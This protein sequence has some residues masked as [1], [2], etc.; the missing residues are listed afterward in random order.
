MARGRFLRGAVGVGVSM[1]FSASGCR[2]LWL[3]DWEYEAA[4]ASSAL[5]SKRNTEN[6]TKSWQYEEVRRREDE[7]SGSDAGK[8]GTEMGGGDPQEDVGPRGR[9]GWVNSGRRSGHALLSLMQEMEL[10]TG[11]AFF[12]DLSVSLFFSCSI[13]RIGAAT[14]YAVSGLQTRSHLARHL[15]RRQYRP[16][17]LVEHLS[18]AKAQNRTKSGAMSGQLMNGSIALSRKG[19]FGHCA[20]VPV[21]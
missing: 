9:R 13:G 17:A 15:S 16:W 1:F 12:I 8:R 3:P 10:T 21:R 5:S 11:Q 14:E 7:G 19:Y 6:S 4:L 2:R 20:D 18:R